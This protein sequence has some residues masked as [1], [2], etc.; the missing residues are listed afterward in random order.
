VLD[1]T[2][3]ILRI[4]G[5]AAIGGA[6]GLNRNLHHKYIGLRTLALIGAAAA[7]IVLVTLDAVDGSTHVDALSRVVQ[8]LLTGVGFIGAGVIVHGAADKG[9]HGL[10]TAASVWT[11]AVLGILCGAG[12]W[13]VVAVLTAVSAVV[14]IFGGMVERR[15]HAL[16]DRITGSNA[17]PD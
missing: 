1:L 2:E 12:V 5:A 17:P 7:G 11:T 16:F 4:G 15:V 6:I 9:V 14:L 8:G 10:T 3:I 13:R